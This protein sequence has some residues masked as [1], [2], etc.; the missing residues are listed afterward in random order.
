M[1]RPALDRL[2]DAVAQGEI[3]AVL[4]LSPDR[5]V[6]QFAY[7]YIVVEEF[8]RAGCAVEAVGKI[9]FD[10]M[11]FSCDIGAAR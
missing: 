4:I 5:L 11:K 3:E 7:Q 8:E 9:R 1:D 6:R 2:R 10:G